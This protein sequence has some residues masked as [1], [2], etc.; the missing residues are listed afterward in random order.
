MTSKDDGTVT[1]D[2]I[3]SNLDIVQGSGSL[4]GADGIKRILDFNGDGRA[5]FMAKNTVTN[6]CEF[7]LSQSN[8]DLLFW[9]VLTANRCADT[10]PIDFNGDGNTDWAVSSLPYGSLFISASVGIDSDTISSSS[11]TSRLLKSSKSVDLNLDG[12]V[13]FLAP[14]LDAI[15]SSMNWRVLQST[16]GGFSFALSTQVK[17]SVMCGDGLDGL[18]GCIQ[19]HYITTDFNGD[20]YP[21]IIS[22]KRD[23]STGKWAWYYYENLLGRDTAS[24]DRVSAITDGLGARITINYKPISDSSVYTAPMYTAEN[25]KPLIPIIDIRPAIKVVSHIDTELSSMDYFYSGARLDRHRKQYLGFESV[26]VSK[27]DTKLL[28][29]K[30]YYQAYPLTDML[31]DTTIFSSFSSGYFSSPRTVYNST[32][33]V[34]DSKTINAVAP[35]KYFEIYKQ[36]EIAK[37]FG[38]HGW[39]SVSPEDEYLVTTISKEFIDINFNDTPLDNY[40]NYEHIITTTETPSLFFSNKFTEKL[41]LK[42]S[43]IID[44]NT[45]LTGLIGEKVSVTTAPDFAKETRKTTY[46]YYTGASSANYG[47][48]RYKNVQPDNSLTKVSYEYTYEPNY[49]LPLATTVSTFSGTYNDSGDAINATQTQPRTSKTLILNNSINE[50]I[51][52]IS[53]T[54]ETTISGVNQVETID[55]R[56]GKTKTLT[57]EN[58]LNTSYQTD[59]FSRTVKKSYANGSYDKTE[60]LQG[61][62]CIFCTETLV[63]SVQ[64]TTYD[65]SNTVLPS[66]I[67]LFDNLK[68]ERVTRTQ[69]MD[70][71][72]ICKSKI[73]YET[74]QFRGR[75]RKETIEYNCDAKSEDTV[76]ATEYIYNILGRPSVITAPDATRTFIGYSGATR[77]GIGTKTTRIRE[78][79]NGGV[80]ESG[81]G[82]LEETYFNSKGWVIETKDANNIVNIYDYDPLG[83]LTSVK[84]ANDDKYIVKMDYDVFGR[85]LSLDDPNAGFWQYRYNGFGEM[86]WQKDAKNTITT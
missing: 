54:P 63:F 12:K 47:L 39:F 56:F 51:Q 75:L 73:Y 14:D 35:Q 31:K 60:Y 34:M 81:V 71:T 55:A 41:S 62:D 24:L 83:N 65:K 11:L 15:D 1:H 29:E 40:G 59:A 38:V 18:D 49:G 33:I 80:S 86:V 22:Q 17:A 85:L 84:I 52:E 48:L 67:V 37:D 28:Q 50:L 13:D 68:R 76:L 20:G 19:D 57:D 78:G 64:T 4:Y 5:D 7:Y 53:I 3:T 70:G 16:D 30:T 43:P 61:D 46:G 45:W 82:I 66:T 26:I 77:K 72:N 74:G 42:Y 9:Q 23:E 32:T 21:D 27:L 58:G 79:L 6:K 25:P 8:S 2:L 44:N 69:N 36:K 10:K